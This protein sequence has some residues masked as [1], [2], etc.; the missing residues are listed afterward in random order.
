[1]KKKSFCWGFE[2]LCSFSSVLH[3]L[4]SFNATKCVEILVR[5]A[6]NKNWEKLTYVQPRNKK[7]KIS[8]RWEKK[9]TDFIIQDI[10]FLFVD[11]SGIFGNVDKWKLNNLPCYFPQNR[12]NDHIFPSSTENSMCFQVYN[13]L[14]LTVSFTSLWLPM[15]FLLPPFFPSVHKAVQLVSRQSST[16][17]WHSGLFLNKLMTEISYLPDECHKIPEV[18]H[19]F[20]SFFADLWIVVSCFEVLMSRLCWQS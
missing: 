20:I 15:S 1:M 11:S 16:P 9:N 8:L 14:A 4:S 18:L 19:L 12:L 5:I 3:S 6:I 13:S 7:V 17:F 2:F 10:F